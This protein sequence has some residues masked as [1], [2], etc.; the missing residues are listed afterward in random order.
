MD[1]E[2]KP[3]AGSVEHMVAEYFN[4]DRSAYEAQ[5]PANAIVDHAPSNQI[6]ILGA[7][8]RDARSIK[9]VIV[10]GQAGVKAGM[11][12]VKIVVP[13]TGHDW[14]SVNATLEAAVP[15]LCAHRWG[16]GETGLTWSDYPRIEV[17]Q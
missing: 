4:G 5:V 11:H 10:N 14:H 13:D 16:L 8:K 12:V 7:G 17:L 9:N 2:L 3:T 1:G 15:W 6:M